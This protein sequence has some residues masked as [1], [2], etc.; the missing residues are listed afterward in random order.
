MVLVFSG[1]F[2]YFVVVVWSLN[3]VW[4]AEGTQSWGL[5]QANLVGSLA[6]GGLGNLVWVFV[7][8]PLVRLWC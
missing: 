6:L 7:A 1:L 3:A 5:L 2:V 4:E 8:V